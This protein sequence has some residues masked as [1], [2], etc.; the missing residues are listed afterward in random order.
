[1]PCSRC[2]QSNASGAL[3]CVRCGQPLAPAGNTAHMEQPASSN[4]APLSSSAIPFQAPPALNRPNASVADSANS[5]PNVPPAPVRGKS[6]SA[7]LRAQAQ[8]SG[9]N[10]AQEFPCRVC[11]A[12]VS[13][14]RAICAACGTPLGMTVNPIDGAASTYFPAGYAAPLGARGR[15]ADAVEFAPGYAVPGEV[16]RRRWHWGAFGLSSLWL[17]KHRLSGWGLIALGLTLLSP[18]ARFGPLYLGLPICGLA[19]SLLLGT[20]GGQIAWQQGAYLDLHH[21]TQDDRRWQWAGI[22]AGSIKI[23]ALLAL[24]TLALRQ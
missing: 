4:A 21:L 11:G 22:A 8:S 15:A 14:R 18:L 13:G 7:G 20:H 24:T 10:A 19:L 23:L 16:L 3:Y 5:M 12:R 9:Q 6:V 2:G 17:L 1:M